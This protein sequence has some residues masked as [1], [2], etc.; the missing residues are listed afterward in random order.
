MYLSHMKSSS[1]NL[2]RDKM[3]LILI[4][5][6][7]QGYAYLVPSEGEA[8]VSIPLGVIDF[9]RQSPIDISGRVSLCLMDKVSHPLKSV[10]VYMDDHRPMDRYLWEEVL[11][12]H[13]DCEMYIRSALLSFAEMCCGETPGFIAVL[14]DE[15]EVW[16]YHVGK[17][18]LSVPSLG[19]LW[20]DK[21]SRV[22]LVR[23]FLRDLL[24]HRLPSSV[25]DVFFESFG[26]S[27]QDLL[28]GVREGRLTTDFLKSLMP[29]LSG[30]LGD[31]AVRS[32]V[33]RTLS[34]Y[35]S[36]TLLVHTGGE[37]VHFVGDMLSFYDS[38]LLD[39][40]HVAGIRVGSV[41][42]SLREVLLSLSL[43]QL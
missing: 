30:A 11:M 1:S 35:V 18:S 12:Q 38:I 29:F 28:C 6:Y 37:A 4:Q 33:S 27:Y 26:L 36:S 16:R 7:G 34:D 13:F 2:Y 42:Y 10:H 32:L 41:H 31:E 17:V 5:E 9:A 15:S 43:S 22:T 40:C 19:T 25:S 24:T 20:G 23:E 21:G 8:M 39:L 3:N 14:G